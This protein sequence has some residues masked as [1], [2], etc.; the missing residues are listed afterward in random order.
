MANIIAPCG[1]L[2]FK[3]GEFKVEEGG[4]ALANPL[5]QAKQMEK[6]NDSTAEE[7]AQLKE[8]FNALLKALKDSGLMKK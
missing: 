4:I 3:Q 8:N 5:A 7:V 2:K 6:I 1:G